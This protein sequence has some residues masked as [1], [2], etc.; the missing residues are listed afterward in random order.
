MGLNFG[1]SQM[2][3]SQGLLN[4]DGLLS[5]RWGQPGSKI[6][7]FAGGIDNNGVFAWFSLYTVTAGKVFYVTQITYYGSGKPH[8]FSDSDEV[9]KLWLQAPD[10]NSITY[11]PKTPLKFTTEFNMGADHSVTQV[12]VNGWEEA[13]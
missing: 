10:T 3:P 9:T 5:E 4:E 12:S 1:G 13:A 6:V 2:F 8:A 11:Q 7:T